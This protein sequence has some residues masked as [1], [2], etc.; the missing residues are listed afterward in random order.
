MF[1]DWIAQLGLLQHDSQCN[2]LASLPLS[3]QRLI[4]GEV[5]KNMMNVDL[6]SPAH[7]KWYMEVLGQGFNLP[8]EDMNITSD[9]VDMYSNWLFKQR[10]Q[11]IIPTLE[12]DFYKTIFHHFSLL[13]QP[14]LYK[15]TSPLVQRHVDLCKKVLKTLLAAGRTLTLSPETWTVLLKVTLGITDYLL[16]EPTIEGSVADELC[17]DLVETLFELWTRSNIMQ[18]E[19][20]NILKT[21][22]HRWTHRSKVIHH[23]NTIC[24]SLTRYIHQLTFLKKGTPFILKF[25]KDTQQQELDLPSE[26]VHYAWHRFTYLI[27]NPL[28]L[29]PHNFT[30]TMLGISNCVDALIRPNQDTS[31]VPTSSLEYPDGNT[32]LHMF[33]NVLF[34]VCASGSYSQ[35]KGFSESFAVLIRIFSTPQ[36]RVPFLPCYIERFYA[37]LVVGLKTD[38]CLPTIIMTSTQL[39]ATNLMGIRML[40]SDYVI[41]LRRI[42]PKLKFEYKGPIYIDNLRL[43]A[44]RVLGTIMCVPNYINYEETW[45]ASEIEQ[46]SMDHASLVGE[47]EQLTTELIRVLYND[48]K[49]DSVVSLKFYILETLVMSLRTET[50][51]YNSRYILHLINVHVIED[52]SFCPGLVGTVIKLIQEKILSM[53]LPADV[54]LVAFDVLMHFVEA[55]E[56]LKRDS[57]NVSRELVLGLCRYI[58]LLIYNS[59][60]TQIYPLVVQAYECMMTWIL[61]S[62]WIMDD[63]DCYKAVIS[64]LSKGIT[65]LDKEPPVKKVTTPTTPTTTTSKQFFQLSPRTKSQDTPPSPTTPNSTSTVSTV[66]K[67]TREKIAVQMAAEYCMSQ[68]INHFGRFARLQNESD[69]KQKYFLVDERIIL[70]ITDDTTH[71][72][73]IEMTVRDCTGKYGWRIHTNYY[74]ATISKTNINTSKSPPYLNLNILSQ[75]D[76][77]GMFITVPTTVPYNETDL[78]TLD[79]LGW[80][81]NAVKQL[82]RQELHLSNKSITSTKQEPIRSRLDDK[83]A[84]RLLLSQLGFLLPSNLDRIKLISE[85]DAKTGLDALDQLSDLFHSLSRRDCI[86]VSIYYARNGGNMKWPDL[87]NTEALTE[88][89]LQFIHCVGWPVDIMQHKRFKGKLDSTLCD[90]FIYYSNKSVELVFNIPYLLKDPNK[91]RITAADDHLCI[92]WMEDMENYKELIKEIKGYS[93]KTM[94]YIFV[95]PLE[96]TGDS[97]YW[98]RILVPPFGSTTS[99]ILASQRLHE[100][101]MIFGPLVDGMI[102]SKHILGSMIRSTAVSA[103][104]ACRIVTG[105][106]TRP[107]VVRRDHIKHMAQNYTVTSSLSSFY[108]DMFQQ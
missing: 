77:D 21:C 91:Q 85:E 75:H 7:I 74:D 32:L 54:T 50:S 97:L 68:F 106:F 29:S 34:D 73:A 1:L 93:D 20:W 78:P 30:I 56:F 37:V 59:N 46:S 25:S 23:W 38:T 49:G 83:G 57:K 63:H 18:V 72:P 66:S 58:D 84:F 105:T 55:Y 89:F 39:F 65:L 12:Q 44:I 107:H 86:S 27:P 53:Q 79:S 69:A 4:I 26:F 22:F 104:Q 67:R 70:A 98:V 8:L 80:E 42:L 14:R 102:I 16:K 99:A 33:G 100:N 43:A 108:M 92:I 13:F 9:D 24:L 19:M 87:I 103:H 82:M 31:T 36:K 71:T 6:R 15:N 41:G 48:E 95:H 64:T 35:E 45:Y 96:N 62:R 5:T 47:Q 76:D 3:S 60:L 52:A 17:D 40:V 101:A 11:V 81:Y 88:P 51:S 10:P 28:L 94:V 90:K 2:I 61:V